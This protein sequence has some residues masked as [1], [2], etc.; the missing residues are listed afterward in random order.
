LHLQLEGSSSAAVNRPAI[1]TGTVVV[2]DQRGRTLG[3]PT[4]NIAIEPARLTLDDGVYAGVFVRPTGDLHACAISLGRRPTFYKERGL[5]LLEAHLLNFSGDLYGDECTIVS[6][7]WVR[8]QRRFDGV[9]DLCAQ[10][11]RDVLEV[12]RM[13]GALASVRAARHLV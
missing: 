9:D 7:C 5:R 2:G 10:L 13:L 1:Y 8:S 4:A 3:F 6:L 11:R 12:Q